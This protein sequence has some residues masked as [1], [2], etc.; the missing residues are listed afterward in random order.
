LKGSNNRSNCFTAA[1]VAVLVIGMII[2]SLQTGPLQVFKPAYAS[3]L[4]GIQVYVGYA[5]NLR[6]GAVN[7][8]TPWQGSPNISFIGGPAQWDAGAIRID[9]PTNTPITI[10][11]V[12]VTLPAGQGR[13]STQNLNLWGTFTIAP[14]TGTILTQTG[15]SAAFNFDTSDFQFKVCNNPAANGE[16]PVPTVTITSGINSQ[17]FSDN[18]HVLDTLGFDLVCL[19]NESTPWTLIGGTTAQYAEQLFVNGLPV[20]GP[21]NVGQNVDEVASSTDVTIDHVTFN[22]K[23]PTNTIVRTQTSAGNTDTF[24]PNVKGPWNVC[25]D[26]ISAGGIKSTVCSPFTVEQQSLRPVGGVIVPVDMTSL[27]VA[28]IFTNAIWMLPTL[29]G[30][31]GAVF[32]LFKVR[33]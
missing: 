22:W 16:A 14:H 25:V 31:A 12:L 2:P 27:F 7:F 26:F 10:D 13:A 11:N 4:A 15:P 20:S 33:K 21:V 5:D 19:H 1:L 6:A 9:N 30:I 23:D 18:G 3:G 24:T 28:G 8:P 32:T 17:V 29:G